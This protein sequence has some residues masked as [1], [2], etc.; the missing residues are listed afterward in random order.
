MLFYGVVIA[1]S[2]ADV[3]K[4]ACACKT[5][6]CARTNPHRPFFVH[7]DANWPTVPLDSFLIK[8]MEV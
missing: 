4:R 5:Q 7:S 6:Q 1:P 2:L 3:V 8:I